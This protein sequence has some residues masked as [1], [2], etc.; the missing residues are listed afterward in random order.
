MNKTRTRATPKRVSG[1]INPPVGR[2]VTVDEVVQNLRGL[3]EHLGL[4]I[5]LRVSCATDGMSTKEWPNPLYPHSSAIGELLTLWHQDPRYLDTLGNPAPLKFRGRRPCFRSLAQLVLPEIDVSYLLS[6][7]KRLRAVT[8]DDANFIHV[9]MR[10][11]SVYEDE[12]LAIQH[13]LT[14]LDGFIKTLRHNLDSTPSNS[15][16]LFHRIA[17]IN[18]FD[19][20]EIPALKIRVRRHG[21]RFLES[22]DNWLTYKALPKSGRQHR[23]TKQA[24]VSLGVYLSVDTSQ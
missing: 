19:S 22:F 20:R 6:E 24:K 13:T 10:S 8:E 4:D 11:L 2:E 14:S 1:N 7:L 16:Q 5:S 18:G 15:N 3:F 23:N 12:R 9:H 17:R 21:Q